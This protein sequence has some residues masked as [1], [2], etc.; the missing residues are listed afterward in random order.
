MP[1]DLYDDLAWLSITTMNKDEEVDMETGLN[2][3]QMA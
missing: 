1:H 3:L 2:L